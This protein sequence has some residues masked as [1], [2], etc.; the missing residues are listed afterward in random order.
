MGLG[1]L[2]G[3]LFV[4]VGGGGVRLARLLGIGL[5]CVAVCGVCRG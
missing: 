5:T 1:G 4:C 2:D 3:L